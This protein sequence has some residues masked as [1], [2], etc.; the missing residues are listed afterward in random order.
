[1]QMK[2]TRSKWFLPLFCVAMGFVFLGVLSVGGDPQGGL[3]SLAIMGLLAGVFLFGGRSETIRGI[4]G[5][6]QDERFRQ[7]DLRATA[8]SGSAVTTAVIIGALVELARG[9]DAM[10]YALLALIGAIAYLVAIA[11]LRVR[12]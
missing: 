12:G 9:E 5:D 4:R 11:V 3:V 1:M 2:L 8:I 10:P 6:G 7:L